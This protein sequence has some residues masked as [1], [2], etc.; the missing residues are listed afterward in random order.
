MSPKCSLERSGRDIFLLFGIANL[1]GSIRTHGSLL[2]FV[3]VHMFVAFWKINGDREKSKDNGLGRGLMESSRGG[4]TFPSE[5][6][7][8]LRLVILCPF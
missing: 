4:N 2:L 6:R 8:W 3:V 5:M 1:L 7:E